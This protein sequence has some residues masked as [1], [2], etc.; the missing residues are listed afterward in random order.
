MKGK[1]RNGVK[2]EREMNNS[3]TSSIIQTRNFPNQSSMIFILQ[4]TSEL[5]GI[6]KSAKCTDRIG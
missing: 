4:T 2:V 1:T 5:G 6:F 3:N